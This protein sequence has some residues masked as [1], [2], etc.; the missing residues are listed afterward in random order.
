MEIFTTT[1]KTFYFNFKFED[2]REIVIEEII[3]KLNEPAKIIDDLKD[4]KD[5]FEN[6]I[7]Y[8]NVAVTSNLKNYYL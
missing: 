4:S 2:E 6:V 7:G 1:N 5:I 8:E 3:K